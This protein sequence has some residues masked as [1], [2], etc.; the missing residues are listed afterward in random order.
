MKDIT[1]TGSYEQRQKISKDEM[2]E[3]LFENYCETQGIKIHHTGFDSVMNPVKEFWKVHPTIRA[4]PDYL[5]ETDNGLSWCQVK[6]SNKLKL[7]DFVEYSTFAN[8]FSHQCDFYVVFMFKD[9]KPIFR[10]MK[11]IANSIVGQEIRQWHDGVKYIT[12]P[13]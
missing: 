13:L 4:L 3:T 2:S 1:N 10:T 11:D 5:V 9:G 8:L 12:V 7:H 6:G